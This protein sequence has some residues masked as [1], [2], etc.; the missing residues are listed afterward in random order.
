MR[1]A[2]GNRA[3]MMGAL[4]V[5]SLAGCPQIVTAGVTLTSP[6]LPPESDPSS[7]ASVLS[8]YH[9]PP[10]VYSF[11]PLTVPFGELSLRC[12]QSVM[13][14]NVG[15][16]EYHTFTATLITTVDIGSGPEPVTFSGP[17]LTIAFDKADVTTGVFAT[18]IVSMS[19][20]GEV[21]GVPLTLR[22]S[23]TFASTG[24][25][26][27]VE[28]CAGIYEIYSFYDLFSE[29]SVDGGQTWIAVDAG[30]YLNLEMFP[31][32]GVTLASPDLP[33]ESDPPSCESV[34]TQYH[35]PPSVYSSSPLTV[36]FGELS[37]RCFQSVVRADL[38]AD[39]Y[40]SYIATL[41]TT[42]DIGSGPELATLTG[43]METIA[44]DKA[45]V[46]TGV[47]Q[48]EIVSMSLSGD[49]GGITLWLRESPT[50]ASTGQ[51][52]IVEVCGGVFD[53]Y[54]AYGLFSEVSVDGGQTWIPVDAVQDLTLMGSE[55]FIDGFESGD[56]SQ[57]SSSVP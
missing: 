2:C 15:P 32:G 10:S 33:P 19:L 54:S 52:K 25:T 48:T 3:V 16:D 53:I 57:W 38:G 56:T 28:T 37:L 51:T 5:I 18:E 36:P 42:V 14:T 13:R 12:F 24:Q 8:H 50:L 39:E 6:D 44:F 31:S 23:P 7:C 55:I 40:Q 21:S 41:V 46:T 29:L 49:V 17:V 35:G 27:I 43:P 22:E 30:Q 4:T 26:A 1:L 20:S 45:A 11:S 34:L 9:G 47:F